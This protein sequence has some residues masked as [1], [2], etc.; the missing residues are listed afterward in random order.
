MY[1]ILCL[2]LMNIY[3]FNQFIKYYIAMFVVY[4]KLL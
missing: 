4:S 2:V 1:I 3:I